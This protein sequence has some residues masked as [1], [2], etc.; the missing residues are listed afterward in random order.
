V[1]DARYVMK[2][3]YVTCF[4][5]L[6]FAIQPNAIYNNVGSYLVISIV[7]V[8]VVIN[9]W[10]FRGEQAEECL[11]SVA[12][13]RDREERRRRRLLDRKFFCVKKMWRKYVAR[14]VSTHKRNTGAEVKRTCIR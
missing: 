4:I 10:V 14:V 13:E 12:A 9:N 3:V 1:W 6:S 8:W 2:Q 5:S 7:R 11:R